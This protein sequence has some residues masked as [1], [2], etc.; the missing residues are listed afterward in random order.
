[1]SPVNGFS[2]L[3]RQAWPRF[4]QRIGCQAIGVSDGAKPQRDTV[5]PHQTDLR[6][7]P[8]PT[9]RRRRRGANGPKAPLT[10]ER[11]AGRPAT[12]AFDTE[13]RVHG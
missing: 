10:L 4:G 5:L 7:Q 3:S 12:S 13:Q 9:L 8:R 11:F 6:P 1:M 2:A